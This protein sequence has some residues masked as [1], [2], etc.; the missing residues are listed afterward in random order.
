[1]STS[2]L[3]N[4]SEIEGD[5][6]KQEILEKE[7][8]YGYDPSKPLILD[9]SYKDLYNS[10]I[11]DKAILSSKHFFGWNASKKQLKSSISI[12]DD[13]GIKLHEIDMLDSSYKFVDNAEF[14]VTQE[15]IDAV[16]TIHP[17]ELPITFNRKKIGKLY[18]L[19]HI[20][21]M[22]G[23]SNSP[24]DN[25]VLYCNIDLSR[26]SN[27][28]TPCVYNHEIT[29][30]QLD[31]RNSCQNLLDIDT[32]PILMEEIFANKIDN[33]GN[34]LEKLRNIRLLE[35][36]KT[37]YSYTTIPNMAYISRIECDAYIKSTFQA[38][39]LANIYLT[40]N[41]NIQKEMHKYI[42]KIFSEQ[43]SVQ[44]MLNQYNANIEDVP[45]C[46]KKLRVPR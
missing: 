26:L 44:D 20:I 40:G 11:D 17:S 39:Q 4:Y 42:N 24:E 37:L 13:L 1:M 30:S 33:S 10:I 45:K 18:G 29:H 21:E 9:S 22:N 31:T 14:I 36:L 28:I 23:A 27:K 38:I 41:P 6:T 5:P 15:F 34:T 7:K 3:F 19:I 25:S 12:W 8:F 46:L 35:I 43:F 2:N 32:L 16:K